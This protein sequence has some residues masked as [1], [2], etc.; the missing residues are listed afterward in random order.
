M[1]SARIEYICKKCGW[2]KSILASWADL[3]PKKCMNKKCGCSFIVDPDSLGVQDKRVAVPVV[4]PAETAIEAVKAES[5]PK[6]NNHRR[7]K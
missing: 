1:D 5:N 7:G 2:R 3:K 4:V 6:V